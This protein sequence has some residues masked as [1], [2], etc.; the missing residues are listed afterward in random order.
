VKTLGL[1]S[2]ERRRLRG[3]LIDMY[4]ILTGNEN[5]DYRQLLTTIPGV[6]ACTC[7]SLEA[8]YESHRSSSV[9]D[10]NRLPQTVVD[11]TSVNMFKKVQS[12]FAETLTLNPNLSL[13]SAN[14]VSASR[15]SANRE[16]TVQKSSRCT[17]ERYGRLKLQLHQL[18][19]LQVQVRK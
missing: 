15:V 8:T 12:Q 14:R 19:I 1:Y 13:I 7:T 18:I 9:N 4:K 17:L 16:D 2:L 6:T 3:D 5:V 10:L 11:A